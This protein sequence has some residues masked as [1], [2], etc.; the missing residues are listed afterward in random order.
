MKNILFT[1]VVLIGF[2]GSAQDSIVKAVS[3]KGRGPF[4]VKGSMTGTTIT[5]ARI[6]DS[7]NLELGSTDWQD[8]ATTDASDLTSGTLPDARLSSN[9]LPATV[10]QNDAEAGTSTSV[11][12]W[13]PQRVKQ[14]IDNLA[15]I[16]DDASP[17]KGLI[18][19][20]G[21]K[22]EFYADYPYP[23]TGFPSNGIAFITDS[24]AP[25]K[26]FGDLSDITK[27]SPLT[28]SQGT[29]RVLADPDTDGNYNEVDWTPPGGGSPTTDASE[30]I[31]GVLADDRVQESNVTQHEGALSI[32]ESQISDL[33]SYLETS[34]L[35]DDDTFATATATNIPSAESVKAYVDANAGGAGV[36]DGD[37]GDIIVSD[38]GATWTVDDGVITAT[39]TDS[40]VQASLSLADTSLQ[41]SILENDLSLT[42]TTSVAKRLG[43]EWEFGGSTYT[44]S[45][46]G[47]N[48]TSYW[49]H[50]V[51]GG[52]T[53]SLGLTTSSIRPI[54]DNALNIG[55]ITARFNQGWFNGNVTAGGFAITGGTS[56]QFLKADGSVDSNTYLQA[57]NASEIGINFSS[58]L[59]HGNGTVNYTSGTDLTY[60]IQPNATVAHPVGTRILINNEAVGGTG[61][62][63]TPGTGVTFVGGTAVLTTGQAAWIVQVTLDEWLII[64]I[65]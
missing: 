41:P 43:T 45:L 37:K 40:G 16:P 27:G 4:L 10:S 48:G 44:N 42:S 19:G 31:T 57:P 56:S 7:L 22:A 62:T 20:P 18:W 32:T 2:L 65:N 50:N 9:A 26:S 63:I 8:G 34:A 52:S 61:L 13:T 38:T 53:G 1:I 59:A 6:V 35:I 23:S 14:A 47:T 58:T 5:G 25:P 64:N 3:L 55:L 17:R 15:I 51:E 12:R 28:S 11:F 49:T 30:L 39:K 29:L 36:T 54:S 46:I 33:G 21:T 24:I 60:T